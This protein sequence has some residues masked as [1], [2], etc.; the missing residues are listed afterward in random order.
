MGSITEFYSIGAFIK[1]IGFGVHKTI[2]K[3]KDPHK[4]V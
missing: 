3:V 4:I 2:L 1:R